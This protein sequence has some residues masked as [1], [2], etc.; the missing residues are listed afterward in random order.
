MPDLPRLGDPPGGAPEAGAHM[1]IELGEVREAPASAAAPRPRDPRRWRW[2]LAAVAAAAVLAAGGAA[3]ARSEMIAVTIAAEGQHSFAGPDGVYFV[4]GDTITKYEPPAAE[5]RWK[6]NVLAEGAAMSAYAIGGIV[7]ITGEAFESRTTALDS[8]TGELLWRRPGL[9]V[10]IGEDYLVLAHRPP[11]DTVERR[12]A[13]DIATGASR[14][15]LTDSYTNEVYFGEDRFVR[16]QSLDRVEVRDLATGRVVSTGTVRRPEGEMDL[17]DSGAQIAGDLLL[18]SRDGG[19]RLTAEAYDLD[20]LARRWSAEI[21]LGEEQVYGC[22]DG[23]CVS[24]RGSFGARVI[25]KQTGRVRWSVDRP[26]LLEEIGQVLVWIGMSEKPTRVQ[27]LDP[28]DG[29]VRTDFGLWELDWYARNEEA[30]LA[31]R[32]VKGGGVWFA[33]LDLLRGRVRVL[34][35]TSEPA[36]CNS[37][38]GYVVCR[39]AGEDVRVWYPRHRA[40]P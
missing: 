9:P 1:L 36:E 2:P 23:L 17:T 33:E 40:Q 7:L 31:T 38:W 16:W 21:D 34:G 19:G 13:I 14:W 3:P 10:R 4:A 28:A 22:G 35:G 26:G 5:P 29:H 24:S 30:V 37:D 32:H 18:V 25:D 39:P 15:T 20:G 6:A 11:A 27:V 8:A 12:E